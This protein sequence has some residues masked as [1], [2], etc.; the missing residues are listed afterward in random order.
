MSNPAALVEI[1]EKLQA[2]VIPA[3]VDQI[4]AEI[5]FL[6][7]CYP[8]TK[9]NLSNE[10][11]ARQGMEWAEDLAEYP[12][13]AVVDAC[14]KYRRDPANK[15][16]PSTSGALMP[17]LDSSFHRWRS[18]SAHAS[19]AIRKIEMGQVEVKREKISQADAIDFVAKLREAQAEKV[20]K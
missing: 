18:L 5:E 7:D 10:V 17:Y 1:S 6:E 4:I 12:M 2:A 9:R 14:R 19:H 15:F 3:R 20:F 11:L 16:A 13:F 8:V